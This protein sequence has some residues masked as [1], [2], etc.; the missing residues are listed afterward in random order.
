MKILI[1]GATGFIGSKLVSRL[2]SSG[3]TVTLLVRSTSDVGLLWDP[4]RH[5]VDLRRMEGY[6]VFV[7]LSGESINGRWTNDKKKK[8]ADSRIYPTRFLSECIGKLKNPPKSF[9]CAS[10]I[11]YYGNRGDEELTENSGPGSGFLADVCKAWESE[12]RMIE[13]KGIRVVNV[14]T[15][16]VLSPEG[17]ALQKLL[18]PFKLGVGGVVGSGRQ[19]WSWIDLNDL[20]RIYQ[21]AI[22]NDNVKGPVNAVAPNTVTNRT[23]VK[24]LARVLRRPAL[25]PLPSFIVKIIF[26]EMGEELLLFGQRVLPARLNE[27]GFEFEHKELEPALRSML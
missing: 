6:D 12:T 20:L 13:S 15:G 26:G 8:I 17:G 23:F 9:V 14:R 7:N 11:G 16:L 18:L 2:R 24:T 25:F 22:E 1:S 27:S 21:Y 4:Y 5:E 10:A 19:W 3:H